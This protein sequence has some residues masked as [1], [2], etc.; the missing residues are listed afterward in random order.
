MMLV[1]QNQICYQICIFLILGFQH[2]LQHLHFSITMN[3]HNYRIVI[4]PSANHPVIVNPHFNPNFVRQWTGQALPVPPPVRNNFVHVN[5][6]FFQSTNVNYPPNPPPNY[7]KIIVNPKFFPVVQQQE[8]HGVQ[9]KSSIRVLHPSTNSVRP[10]A[11]IVPHVHQFNNQV[12]L[13]IFCF[14]KLLILITLF[15][16]THLILK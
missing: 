14:H 1:F 5:P 16:I 13:I 7:S 12:L 2:L 9:V 4:P 15:L 3:P 8:Q 11:A 10:R 6:A